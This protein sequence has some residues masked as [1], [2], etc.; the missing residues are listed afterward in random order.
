M[1]RK[2][3]PLALLVGLQ[4]GAATL[5]NSKEFPQEV[6]NR[7]ALPSSI[8][9]LGIYPQNTK[10]LIQKDIY[11]PTFIAASSIIVKLWKQPKCPLMDE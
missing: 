2:G 4:T 1:W 6:K 3:N 10:V 5:E 8:V 11:T 9:L 7:T